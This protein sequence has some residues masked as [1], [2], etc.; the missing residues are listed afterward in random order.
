MS[1]YDGQSDA[2]DAARD[3]AA[4]DDSRRIMLDRHLRARGISDERLLAVMAD[5]PR[6]RFVPPQLAA[7]AYADSA[8]PI[9]HGQTISQP[10]IVALMTEQLHPRPD[11]RVLEIGTGS[12]YQAAVLARLCAHVFTIERI[13]ELSDAAAARLR[14]LGLNNVTYRVGDGTMG[15]PEEAAFDGIIVT[16][17]APHVPAALT[18]QLALGG[19][20]VVPV[21]GDAEQ[22]LRVLQRR[23]GR[24]IEDRSVP[25]RFVRLIGADGWST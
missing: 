13:A 3:L 25:C 1:L 2:Y 9:D 16:A 12:G 11:H 15:W 4:T 18:Q 17:G 20:L 14:D 10:Y 7:S 6:E 23:P 5:L 8:L 21:G 19:R 22:S 24:I